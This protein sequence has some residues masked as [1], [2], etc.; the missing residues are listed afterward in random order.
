MDKIEELV[1]RR[2]IAL[3]KEMGYDAEPWETSLLKKLWL[4]RAVAVLNDPDL[5]LIDQ[6]CYAYPERGKK[7]A[8]VIPLAKELERG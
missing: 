5:A 7:L 6:T 4:G 3:R 8:Y 1:E 2:A